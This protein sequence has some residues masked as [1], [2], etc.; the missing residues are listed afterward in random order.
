MVKKKVSKVA[1]TRKP[2]NLYFVGGDGH[3]YET[4]MARGGKKKKRK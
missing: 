4:K 3:V 1:I 2:G